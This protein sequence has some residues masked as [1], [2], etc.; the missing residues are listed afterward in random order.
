MAIALATEEKAALFDCFASNC[1]DCVILIHP[2]RNQS[3]T[4]SA[5]ESRWK[6]TLGITCEY[7]STM[8]RFILDHS[9]D[10]Q[11]DAILESLKLSAIT[12][13]LK[14]AP[15][16]AITFTLHDSEGQLRVKR[17]SFSQKDPDTI[18]L[19][20]KDITSS[21]QEMSNSLADLE[22]S[23]ENTRSQ[24][25]QRNAFLDRMSRD[26][27]TPLFS[28]LGLTRIAQDDLRNESA[29]IDYLHKISMSGS[30]MSETIDDI[31]DLRRMASGQTQ[32]RSNVIDLRD[33]FSNIERMIIPLMS[34]NNLLFSMDTVGVDLLHVVTDFHCLQQTILKML[35]IAAGYTLRGGRISLSSRALVLSEKSTTIELCVESRGVVINRDRMR[36]LFMPM[37]YLQNELAQRIETEDLSLLILKSNILAMG[38]DTLTVESDERRGTRILVTLTLPL[39][40]DMPEGTLE[41]VRRHSYSFQSLHVLLVDDNQISLEVGEKLLR[42]KDMDVVT[43]RDGQEAIDLFIR[44]KGNF[45]L[46]LM[47]ILMPGVDGYTATRR[48]REMS[49]IPSAKTIPIIAMTVNA[50][51]DSFEESLQ[52]GMNAYLEK[53]FTPEQLYQTISSVL[54][55]HLD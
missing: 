4:V 28:I 38:S 35:R 29:V 50:F 26:I 39:S 47:D 25:Q 30:Y 8:R 53:P 19:I 18:L 48:I 16:Y 33:F 21:Y 52:V 42:S 2:S 10:T 24:L 7:E 46:I 32:L 27:R 17:L 1:V 23:L 31:L 3:I 54:T 14:A 36:S 9:A 15:E 51:R 11:T 22:Q 37:D 13:G 45:D 20:W 44:E 41:M 55:P 43:A 40:D 12:K 5:E 49:H 6:K 34:Q